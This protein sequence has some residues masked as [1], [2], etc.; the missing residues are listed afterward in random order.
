MRNHLS[1]LISKLSEIVNHY[2]K[3]RNNKIQHIHFPKYKILLCIYDGG[4][5]YIFY[6]LLIIHSFTGKKT[7]SNFLVFPET[8]YKS[9]DQSKNNNNLKEKIIL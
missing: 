6:Y 5:L 9:N 7:E 8:E 4:I 1:F 2:S 3:C